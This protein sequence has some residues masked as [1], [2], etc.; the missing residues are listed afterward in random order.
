MPSQ[1][2]TGK[3]FE[4]SLLIEFY[5]KLQRVTN[6]IIIK[7]EPF[8]TAQRCF[9]TFSEPKKEDYNINSSAAVNIILDLEPRL[10]H[11]IN[12]KDT[13]QLELVP[14]SAG[15][16][17]DVRDILLIRSS[18]DWIIGISAKNNHKAVKH[19][20]LSQ[21][22]DFGKKW[23]GI[24]CSNN[25]FDEIRPIFSNLYNISK[26]S[27][28]A[29][30]NSIENMHEVV[31]VP[32]LEAFKDELLRL[33]AENLEVVPKRLVE[34]L[35]GRKDFYKV[36]KG[37]ET[38]EVQAFNLHGT[39]NLPF[40]DIKP[41]AKYSKLKLPTKLMDISFAPGTLT[42]LIVTLNEG[43]QLSFRIHNASSRVEASLK[44]DINLISTP[45]TLF[46]NMTILRR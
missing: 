28:S 41:K 1:T 36:I 30:W 35:I 18:Q 39:L 21:T 31:Y 26:R 7:N 38:V 5:S 15:Q 45:E 12:E 4:Y 8:Y 37:I 46:K 22:I 27:P 33:N 13:L 10:S 40:N 14:D 6:V 32:I 24:N 29:L 43:W 19:S 17:G 11:G 2:I 34:Y 16:S 25:Y 42:T 9:D 23:L 44:F 3:A 20:R